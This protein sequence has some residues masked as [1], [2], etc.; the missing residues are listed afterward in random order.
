MISLGNVHEKNGSKIVYNL[1]RVCLF[2]NNLDKFKT[3]VK[4][5]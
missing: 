4:E 1:L 5:N 2:E 3:D